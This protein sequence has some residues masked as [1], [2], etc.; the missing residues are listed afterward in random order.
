M[1]SRNIHHFNQAFLISQEAEHRR[2]GRFRT[3]SVTSGLGRVLDLSNCGALVLK[4]RFAKVPVLATFALTIRYEACK[5]T[6]NARIARQSKQRGI[7]TLLGLEF[8]DVTE[9]QVDALRDIIRNSRDWEVITLR[10]D[11]QDAA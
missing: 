2:G 9:E 5:V 11:D 8:L 3:S 1:L 10:S 7:G 4:K 6:M